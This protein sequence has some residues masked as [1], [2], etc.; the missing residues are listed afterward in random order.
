MGW[1]PE[2]ENELEELAI[3]ETD[4]VSGLVHECPECGAIL[5]VSDATDL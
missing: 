2:C 4:V 5:G 3:S 1:C